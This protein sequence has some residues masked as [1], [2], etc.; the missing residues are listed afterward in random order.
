MYALPRIIKLSYST[1]MTRSMS[2][3]PYGA[4]GV[5][6]VSVYFSLIRQVA[7]MLTYG[8]VLRYIIFFGSLSHS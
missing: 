8:A 2:R 1:H 7:A 4:Y 6:S 3:Y 5:R